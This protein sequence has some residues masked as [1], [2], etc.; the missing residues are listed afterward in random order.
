M[1]DIVELKHKD[2]ILN[3]DYNSLE[4]DLEVWDDYL[5]C[6]C[7]DR[8][9]QKLAIKTAIKYLAGK[10]YLNLLDLAKE[11]YKKSKEIK[12]A[13]VDEKD[14]LSKF[15]QF[16]KKLFAN[17]DLATGTGKSYII[18][19]IAQ[20]MLSLGLVK[21]ILVLCPS[22]TIEDGL[23]DKFLLL[24][25]RKDLFDLIPEGFIRIT[26]SIIDST[27]TI[28]NDSICIENIHAVYEKTGSS[29]KDSLMG[30]GEE[31][32]VL[33]DESHHI[34]NKSYQTD[35]DL[36]K[37][38]NFLLN[39]KYGFKY[40]LG[41]TGTAYQGDNYFNDVIF[42]YSLKD[43]IEQGFVKNV[44][45]IADSS[46][47]IKKDDE[48]FQLI[49]KVHESNKIQY[50]TVLKPL[51]IL[52]T[53]DIESAKILGK[54][55]LD[56]LIK[57]ELLINSKLNPNEL[58]KD[59]S[60]K[61]LIINHKSTDE[62]KI[63]LKNVDS[64]TNKVEWI[65][66]VS[67]LNEGWDVKNVFQIIPM[68]ERAFSSKLLISQVLGRGLRKPEGI[69]NP[70]VIVMNHDSWGKNIKYLVD[71]VLELETRLEINSSKVREDLNFIIKNIDY[72]KEL[73]EVEKTENKNKTYNYSGSFS[74]G[75]SLDAQAPIKTVNLSFENIKF[76]Q[77]NKKDFKVKINTWTIEEVLN[78]IYTEFNQRNWEGTILQIGDNIYSKESL[79]PKELIKEMINKSL[80]PRGIDENFIEEKNVQKLLTTFSTILR[81][82][83][84][85][86]EYKTIYE[87]PFEIFTCKAKLE[88]FGLSN[89]RKPEYTFF[90]SED[91]EIDDISDTQKEII[92]YFLEDESFPKSSTKLVKNELL[93]TPFNFVVTTSQ[94]EKRFI[95]ELT[96][97]DV[98]KHLNSWIK[99][100]NKGF[101]SINYS[102]KV[103]TENSRTQKQKI[104]SFNP[105]LFIKVLKN[106][107][108]YI[109]VN[110]IKADKD[111]CLENKAKYKYSKK[112]FEVLNQKLKDEGK[113]EVYI[114]HM[115]S[116]EGYAAYFDWLKDGRLFDQNLDFKCELENLLENNNIE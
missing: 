41:F 93:K 79:P 2:L 28:Q 77:S 107:I 18:F 33:N 17:I 24:S 46:E 1:K 32:L 106:N 56:F 20:I 31:T 110:E 22:I 14:F 19:G 69:N 76:N 6:L 49:L 43:A 4:L 9:Y 44:E 30:Y 67:M 61:I 91:Y 99:S 68:E 87:N 57:N 47:F 84:K 27:S 98:A 38:A 109:L 3:V 8:E 75:V 12:E 55:F 10:K 48:K 83:T 5:D 88:S 7:Q 95:E 35:N 90:Y 92:K 115:L 21:K 26:P 101:Y 36:K 111:D 16:G 23:N 34:F 13:F 54:K 29:I 96:K 15:E 89:F 85:T 72:T 94:P 53:K 100:K 51:S 66:S 81:K 80:K 78:K 25:S 63:L 52:V 112:H 105:D 71:E 60:K 73:V 82:T 86:V 70:K 104:Q 42:R 65:I 108:T 97:P 40:I 74:S 64:K 103:G 58:I 113:N 62:E 11:N 102:V 59:L 37:W 114:F 116:P 50:G 45:Y 39:E